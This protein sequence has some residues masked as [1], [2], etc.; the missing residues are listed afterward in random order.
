MFR[1][2]NRPDV[3]MVPS[4]G[5]ILFE[6]DNWREE[7]RNKYKKA[8]FTF[9]T[10][11][12]TGVGDNDHILAAG[13]FLQTIKL[14]SIFEPTK[15]ESVFQIRLGLPDN[16]LNWYLKYLEGQFRGGLEKGGYDVPD[17]TDPENNYLAAFSYADSPWEMP[18]LEAWYTYGKFP[19][20]ACKNVGPGFAKARVRIVVNEIYIKDLTA[21][22]MAM[23]QKGEVEVVKVFSEEKLRW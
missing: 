2:L 18:M 7:L 17:L 13:D 12:I 15:W 4:G 19:A 16:C 20:F 3:P 1:R 8:A 21:E 11:R 5:V 14:E 23:V 6:G 22:E 9:P 10:N